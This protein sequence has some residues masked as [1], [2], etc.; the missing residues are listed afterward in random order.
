MEYFQKV[1]TC[2]FDAY[3]QRYCILKILEHFIWHFEMT[4]QSFFQFLE[5][6]EL[7]Y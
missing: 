6:H 4:L 3:R 7:K 2:N 5:N 1:E